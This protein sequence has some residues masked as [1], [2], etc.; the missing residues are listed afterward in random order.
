M[1]QF[2]LELDGR[3]LLFI[4]EHLRF[5][6]LTPIVLF[7][8]KLGN[9]GLIWIVIAALL[10]CFKRYRKTGTMMAVSLLI[11]Y[12]LTNL[13]LKNVVMRVRPYETI[14]ALHA[15]AGPMADWSFPSGHATSSIA[16]CYVM[17]K[18]MPRYFGIP[19]FILG[20]FICLS[21][22]YIGVHYPTDVI[23]GA[24]IGLFAA[25]SAKSIVK[26]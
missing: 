15:L 12:V 13:I 2:L 22:L 26:S 1:L 24:I 5:D 11:G 23:A 16:A 4:Q 25:Y 6:W 21:R 20:I 14:A 10:L 19:A 3:I 8:T 17:Y 7:I 18:E 9:E